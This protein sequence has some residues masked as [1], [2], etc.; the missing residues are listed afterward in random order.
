MEEKTVRCCGRGVSYALLLV[1]VLCGVLYLAKLGSWGL[2]DPDE[3]RYAEIPREM[4]ESG[5]W[6]TPH[7]DYVKYFEKPPLLY[8]FVAATIRAFGEGEFAARLGC[9]VPAIFGILFVFCFARR[10][11]GPRPALYAAVILGTSL[12]YAAMGHS[13]T[14][15][16]LLS[17]LMAAAGLMWW[18]GSERPGRNWGQYAA[19]GGL[20]GLAILAKGPVAL[21]LMGG[22]VIVY[23]AW[24]RRWKAIFCPQMLGALAV[25]S[26]V[27]V[28][29][30]VLVMRYNPDFAHF[31]F[32]VQH[33]ERFLPAK[34]AAGATYAT[35]SG[36]HAKPAYW[37][38]LIL[39]GGLLPWTGYLPAALRQPWGVEASE[40]DVSPRRLRLFALLWAG[41]IF[42]FFSASSCKLMP[43]I[44]PVFPVLAIVLGA[45]FADAE[46]KRLTLPRWPAVAMGLFAIG[47]ALA[48]PSLAHKSKDIPPSDLMPVVAAG[49]VVL[50]AWGATLIVVGLRRKP[51]FWALAGGLAAFLLTLI[52]ALPIAA[53]Y[54][55]IRKPAL[56]VAAELKPGDIV[57][58]YRGLNQSLSYYTHQ[59]VMML[60]GEGGPGTEILF[61]YQTDPYGTE[62]WQRNGDRAVEELLRGKQRVFIVIGQKGRA[63]F[64]QRFGG[65]YK[66]FD[67]NAD[68]VFVVN[69]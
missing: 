19:A 44:L 65:L 33:V 27:A 52:C 26:A 61:G 8:W 31:F 28:P 14:T 47:G 63:E 40:A 21:V 43:Y 20:L 57:A 36:E 55:C 45:Y 67:E 18:L 51:A 50:V 13:L 25:M 41:L 53:P 39:I 6:I 68:R 38:I 34:A 7:L 48:I 23:T 12:L 64:E 24:T 46:S 66:Y 56:H 37:F 42:A 29:W 1:L 32:W 22:V 54:K 5:D 4:V 60:W 35:P 10:T 15:D 59:R 16:M 11:L 69:R 49:V 9:A 17:V 62:A 30:F 3:G 58:Q 2:F